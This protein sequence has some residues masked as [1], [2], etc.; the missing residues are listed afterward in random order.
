MARKLFNF[1]GEAATP[2]SGKTAPFY[3]NVVAS[4]EAEARR[5]VEAKSKSE[6][7]HIWEM[8]TTK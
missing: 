7:I 2:D 8:H 1:T 6:G 4:S 5:K 3:A